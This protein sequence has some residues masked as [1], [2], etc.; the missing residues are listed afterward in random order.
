[1]KIKIDNLSLISVRSKVYEG[2]TYYFATLLENGFVASCSCS[3]EFFDKYKTETR[4]G[5]VAIS[6]QIADLGFYKG[7]AKIKLI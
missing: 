2:K 1:M 6:G 5:P 3:Q 7:T 4:K